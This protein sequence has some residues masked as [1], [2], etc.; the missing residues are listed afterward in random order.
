MDIRCERCGTEYEFDDNR[1]TEAGITVKCSS[2]GHMFKIRKKSFVLTEP[3]TPGAEEDSGAAKNWMIRKPDGQMLSFKELTT[4]QKWIVER[5]VSREDEIS[6]SGESWK[7]LGS[8]AELASFFRV[9]DQSQPAMPAM[10]P[11]AA[12]ITQPLPAVVPPAVMPGSPV[13][14]YPTAPGVPVAMVPPAPAMPSV[15]GMPAVPPMGPSYSQPG[16][17]QAGAMPFSGAPLSQPSIPA[18]PPSYPAMPAMPPQPPA[19]AY[20]PVPPPA[21]DGRTEPDSWGERAAGDAEDDDV[22]EKW[23]RRGRRKWMVI[24]PLLMVAL[25]AG[26]VYLLMPEKV[27][28]LWRKLSGGDEISALALQQF[29]SGMDAFMKDT[30]AG[31]D[32]AASDFQ[33]AIAES[34]GRFAKA[35]AALAQVHLARMERAR[36]RVRAIESRWQ[37][38]EAEVAALAPKDGKEPPAEA[39]ARQAELA[40]EKEKLAAERE[41]L[42]AA[43]RQEQDAAERAIAAA[44]AIEPESFEARTAQAQ[45]LRVRGSDRAQID[46]IVAELEKIR[47]Q[48]PDLLFLSGAA[49]AADPAARDT[50]VRLLNA[51]IESAQR[52]GR[53]DFLRSRCRLARVLI[54]LKRFDEAKVQLERILSQS[55]DHPEAKELLASLAPPPPP[56]EEKKPEEKKPEEKPAA[57][58]APADYDGW[59]AQ[60]NRLQERGRSQ[61]ALAAYQS[62]LGFKP[63]DVEAQSGVGLCYLDLGNYS[64][65]IAAFRK[66]LQRNPGYADAV[67]GLAEANRYL[68]NKDEA[69]KYYQKYLDILP[70]GPEAAVARRNLEELK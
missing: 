18:A 39:K 44:R 32:Q 7:K 9:V 12:P 28:E 31:Y 35:Q 29:K 27:H 47:P 37:A 23:R 24:V 13:A 20:P 15:P 6:K 8:I 22:V 45:L 2:C 33:A 41:A 43:G 51:A 34:Q 38:L 42:A 69:R 10:V 50:A 64:A 60:A 52:E 48:D 49:A 63:D 46:V 61:E 56:P 68:G 17:P 1:V 16:M 53:P 4:L 36:D 62:A 59:M 40:T 65:A 54:D 5:K 57:P 30:P 11:P 58:A 66:A 26:V 14:P 67:M 21:A 70:N 25:G 19:P 55:P 3:V